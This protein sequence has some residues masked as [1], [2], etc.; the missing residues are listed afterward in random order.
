MERSIRNQFTFKEDDKYFDMSDPSLG[1]V[2]NER[3]YAK[4]LDNDS[5]NA[6]NSYQNPQQ[7]TN[8]NNEVVH[9][10]AN[11]QV[12]NQVLSLF[13]LINPQDVRV[14]IIGQDPYHT[15]GVANGIAFATKN[16]KTPPSL[17]NIFKELQNDLGIVRT[18]NDLSD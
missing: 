10:K 13:K 3:D 12:T 8:N 9:N 6:Y 7:Q 16:S 5:Q 14:V 4:N 15:P 1:A 11:V 18:D 17:K 2:Y